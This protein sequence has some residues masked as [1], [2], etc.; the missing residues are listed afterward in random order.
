MGYTERQKIRINEGTEKL[1]GFLKPGPITHTS[2]IW[3]SIDT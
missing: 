2:R 3:N 1:K